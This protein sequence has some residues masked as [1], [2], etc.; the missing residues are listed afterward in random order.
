MEIDIR[1][2]PE[3]ERLS[4]ALAAVEGLSPKEVL[5]LLMEDDDSGLVDSLASV[6]GRKYDIQRIRWG[7]K[8]L[9]WVVHVKK[10]LKPSSY[11]PEE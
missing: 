11:H 8:D 2:I 9:P 5:T 3:G 4:H 6:L 1:Q 7:V 10:A